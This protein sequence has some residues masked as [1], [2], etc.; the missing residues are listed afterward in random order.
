MRESI[1]D[2]QKKEKNILLQTA[3]KDCWSSADPE[4]K[5]SRSH[6]FTIILNKMQELGV[7]GSYFCFQVI[8]NIAPQW[9]FK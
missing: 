5:K 9:V 6:F 3:L 8:W 1:T 7:L 2:T 4:L